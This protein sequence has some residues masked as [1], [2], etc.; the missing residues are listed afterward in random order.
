MGG[1]KYTNRSLLQLPF[2]FFLKR[3]QNLKIAHSDVKLYITTKS[4]RMELRKS[5]HND[6]SRQV[7]I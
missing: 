3:K 5:W 7:I 6:W 2:K 4:N 1:Q